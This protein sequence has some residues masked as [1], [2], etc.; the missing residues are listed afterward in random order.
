MSLN[1]TF[2][3][4]YDPVSISMRRLLVHLPWINLF[5][6]WSL[7]KDH[8]T[9]FLDIYVF[10]YSVCMDLTWSHICTCIW[11][12]CL[13]MIFLTIHCTWSSHYTYL[14]ASYFY[15]VFILM[16]MSHI[17]PPLCWLIYIFNN[18]FI[19]YRWYCEVSL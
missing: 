13:I 1:V 2:W 12:I 17:S 5:F 4:H 3:F 19:V 14:S 6:W 9:G 11:H 8:N 10:C 18:L 7:C 16:T 15:F